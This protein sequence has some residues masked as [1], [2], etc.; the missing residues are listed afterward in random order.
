[1][2]IVYDMKITIGK[3]KGKSVEYLMINQPDY[4]KWILEQHDVSGELATIQKHISQLIRK[5]DK[6][7]FKGQ[8]CSS[9][10][11]NKSATKFTINKQNLDPYWWCDACEPK[12]PDISSDQL[13]SNIEYLSIIQHVDHRHMHTNLL[14]K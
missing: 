4:I 7:P 8:S 3:Y 1:L 10:E 6:K 13:P 9:N 5:F 12:Y 11:C 14:F 2:N